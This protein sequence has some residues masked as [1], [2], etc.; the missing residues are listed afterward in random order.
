MEEKKSLIWEPSRVKM[1]VL[2]VKEI[3]P[4]RNAVK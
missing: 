1:Y 2:L 4:E 3:P